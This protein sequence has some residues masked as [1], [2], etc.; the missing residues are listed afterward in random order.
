MP[1]IV[2]RKSVMPAHH[3]ATRARRL[4][5][6]I[7][8][9]LLLASC[10]SLLGIE[11]P[12]PRDCRG[13][14]C[15]GEANGGVPNGSAGKAAVV[16]GSEN[17]PTEGGVGGEPTT[18][19]GGAGE[20]GQIH[21]TEIGGAGGE[22]GG[23]PPQIDCENGEKRCN[24]YQRQICVSGHWMDDGPECAL[25]C[26]DG[27]CQN[28]ASCAEPL[29][30]S[31]C[32]DGASC[33]ETIWMDGGEYLMGDGD[34]LDDVSYERTVSGFYL[35]RFEVTVGR[36]R[37]FQDA[38]ALP[39]EGDGA[40]PLVVGSGW[41]K[42]WED[43]PHDFA[44]GRKAVPVDGDD[45]VLQLTDDC[46]TSTWAAAD[47]ELP[48]NC[49]NWY[50]AFAFCAFDGGRLPTE[51]EWNY[52]AAFGDAQ[53]P[54]PWS[55][56]STDTIID[57]TRATF[58]DYP[59]SPPDSPTAVGSH[60]T[61][62][63]G[64]YRFLGRGHDDLAGNISE[65]VADSWQEVPEPQCADCLEGWANA[66]TDHVVRGGAFQSDYSFLR[67][68]SRSSTPTASVSSSFGFRCA[69]DLNTEPN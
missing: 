28:P 66:A 37:V 20:G 38:Y 50:V 48:I 2:I 11:D 21:S 47:P 36:F 64:F 30:P 1:P 68:G 26:V 49:V 69:R 29:G 9:A 52:A 24:V 17:Q 40:H 56:T 4:G 65:W 39:N 61:G 55:E 57:S 35:D 33:C 60:S 27:A 7:T 44:D 6:S 5:P 8:G 18:P 42:A 67:V 41:Q 51:A 63:G 53:R 3:L 46:D 32:V 25:A 14:A 34:D 62:R 58:Y 22:T 43:I 54:Y 59:N 10:S 19:K 13:D 31:A 16:A 15:A 45:L 12:V 23:A